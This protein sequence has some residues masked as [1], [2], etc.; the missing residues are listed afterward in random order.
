MAEDGKALGMAA[1]F[2]TAVM[3]D[4]VRFVAAVL[5]AEPT[6]V[7]GERWAQFDLGGARLALASGAGSS[8]AA[9]LM[10]KVADVAGVA[11][12]L[13]LAGFDV[14]GPVTGSHEVRVSVAGPDGWSVVVYEPR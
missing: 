9:Q 13:R 3:A 14:A 4:G 2:P 10:V 11:E 12:R 6:F 5:G 1:V 7:G 8:G